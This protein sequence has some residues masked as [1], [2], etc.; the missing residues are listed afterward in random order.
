M[1]GLKH[2]IIKLLIKLVRLPGRIAYEFFF[3][4]YRVLFRVP[5]FEGKHEVLYDSEK[6]HLAKAHMLYHIDA[7]HKESLMISFLTTLSLFI[8]SALLSIY[9]TTKFMTFYSINLFNGIL[10]WFAISLFLAIVPSRFDIPVLKA[11][12]KVVMKTS[13]SKSLYGGYMTIMGMITK[14]HYL[15]FD[16]LLGIVFTVVI[17]PMIFRLIGFQ[18]WINL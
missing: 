18:A 7:Y 4:Q 12:S 2:Q 5:N 3:H 17:P 14:I 13:L 15:G 10:Y 11:K 9:S 1:M 6:S 16:I 8:T